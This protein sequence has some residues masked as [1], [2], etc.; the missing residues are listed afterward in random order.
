MQN[1]TTWSRENAPSLTLAVIAFLLHATANLLGFY[2]YFR[3]EFYYIACTDHLAWG[4]VDHPPLSIVLLWMSRSLFGDSLF[5]IRL[6]PAISH[7]AI[8]PMTGILTRE[9][10]GGTRS[11]FIASFVALP[12]RFIS[13][14]PISTR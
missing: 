4:Y 9:F 5:A 1:I 6:L 7:A 8:V 11:R 13:S 14:S 3:D 10:G 12:H 2:D